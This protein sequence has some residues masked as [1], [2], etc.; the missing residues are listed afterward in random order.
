M[1]GEEEKELTAYCGL[2]CADCIH[3]QNKHSKIARQLK[4]ELEN[5]DF[6]SYASIKSPFGAEFQEYDAF[7]TVLEALTNHSCSEGCR[8]SGG[9]GAEP[10]AII[11]CCEEKDYE[12]CWECTAFETCEKFAALKPRCKASVMHNLKEIREN[13]LEGWSNRRVPI[14]NWQ[15]VGLKKEPEKRDKE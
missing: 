9:C 15:Q 2:Y 5:I 1:N 11:Q 7:L 12:G 4:E 10:C 8:S 13:G 14:Y 3:F 6:H